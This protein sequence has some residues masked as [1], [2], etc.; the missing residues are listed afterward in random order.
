MYLIVIIIIIFF[1]IYGPQ[2]W[3]RY[4]LKKYNRDEYFSGTGIE[5]ARILLDRLSLPQIQVEK[6]RLP[7]HYD[8]NDKVLRLSQTNCDRKS[9]T[10]VV[11]AAHEVGHA[12]Q[13]VSGYLPLKARNRMIRTTQKLE[14]IGAVLLLGFPVVGLVT[15]MPYMGLFMFMAGLI[16][17]GIP[18]IIHLITLPVEFD[19]SFNRAL[20]LLESGEYIPREDLPA[21]RRILTACAWTYVAATLA[22]LLNFWRWIRILRA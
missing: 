3:T 17:L 4:I 10:A 8:P 1:V 16:T 22:G 5:F 9:L 19:A 12:M 6:T 21:A 18:I 14:K 15:R 7:D 13:D 2:F 11:V 20:P